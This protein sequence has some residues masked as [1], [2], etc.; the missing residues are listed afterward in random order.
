MHRRFAVV[1]FLLGL[2]SPLRPGA[3]ADRIVVIQDVSGP[4]AAAG[5][6]F[7]RGFRLGIAYASHNEHP[8]RRVPAVELLDDGSDPEH[9]VALLEG[10][11]A[12]PGLRL[13]IGSSTAETTSALAA[14]AASH[15]TI[16]LM[17]SPAPD[18]VRSRQLFALAPGTADMAR[19][20][21]AT[22]SY[23]LNNISA[24]APD[25]PLGHL[26]AT[27]LSD[28]IFNASGSLSMGYIST[29]FVGRGDAAKA[30]ALSLCDGLQALH[31]GRSLYLLW[32]DSNLPLPSPNDLDVGPNGVRLF[33]AAATPAVLAAVAAAPGFEGI[34]DYDYRLPHNKVNDWL[35][36]EHRRRFG[37]P[38]GRDEETGM[39]AALLAVGIGNEANPAAEIAAL[40]QARIATAKGVMTIRASD[41]QAVR[42]LYHFRM[43]KGVPELVREW[44][45]E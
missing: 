34:V 45:F 37:T 6:A 28:A 19:A 16:L 43:R 41:H 23:P 27:A 36:A 38:P 44:R 12:Q 21:A 35:V 5:K 11:T 4:A 32:G 1:A 17:S 22:V 39:A 14:A 24:L 40:E 13:V 18:A 25:T 26:A 10:A 15:Q 30:A 2:L 8:R 3:A 33:G 29:R 20:E 31:G 42:P 7:E 9:A